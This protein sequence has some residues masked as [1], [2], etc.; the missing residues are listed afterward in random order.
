[1]DNWNEFIKTIS[2]LQGVNSITFNEITKPLIKMKLKDFLEIYK[3][4]SV[5]KIPN[6]SV[7]KLYV[8][9]FGVIIETFATFNDLKEL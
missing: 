9:N 5:V 2:K 8:E 3:E 1:M 4:F 6:D 7:C